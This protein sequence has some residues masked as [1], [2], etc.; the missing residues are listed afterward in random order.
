MK[1]EQRAVD[2]KE[3]QESIAAEMRESENKVEP[4]CKIMATEYFFSNIYWSF[5]G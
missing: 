4:N 2:V 3:E 5:A 1:I